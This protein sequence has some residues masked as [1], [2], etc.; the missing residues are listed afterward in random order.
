LVP[1]LASTEVSDSLNAA[2]RR[3]KIRGRVHE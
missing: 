2:V 1:N 3:G